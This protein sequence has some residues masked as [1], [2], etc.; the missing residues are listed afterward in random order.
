[1]ILSIYS[2]LVLLYSI[3]GGKHM[4]VTVDSSPTKEFFVE[5]LTRDIDLTDAILDLLDNCLDGVL[6]KSGNAN[7]KKDFDYSGYVANIQIRNDCFIIQDNCGGISKHIAVSSAFR[8]GRDSTQVIDDNLPT[9]GIYG[10]GMKRAIF[11]I[12]REAEVIS[13]C[14]NE[15]FAVK[16]PYEWTQT[17]SWELNLYDLDTVPSEI[18]EGGVI[19]RISHLTPA[20]MSVWHDDDKRANFVDDLCRSI[21]KSYSF[22]IEKGF[23]ITVNGQVLSSLPVKLLVADAQNKN[24]AISPYIYKDT[25]NGVDVDLIVGFYT[26]VKSDEEIDAINTSH[27][28]T[29]DA[30]WTIICNDRVVLY[31]DKTHLT[32]WGEGGIPKYHTQFI[33][34]KGV[35]SFRS[36]NP[37]L[38]PTTTT[39][40]GIDLSSEIYSQV[41]ERMRDGLGMFIS[42]T[43]QWK[44]RLPEE[45]KYSNQ[46]DSVS[47]QSL[48]NNVEIHERY[49][50]NDNLKN[51][52]NC[53]G[54]FYIPTLPKPEIRNTSQVI[55]FFKPT[56]EIEF[57][58]ESLLDEELD[59]VKP[60][61]IGELCFDR[62]YKEMGGK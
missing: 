51:K 44:G 20:I 49:S 10:I 50:L 11:K 19:V 55:R 31:N 62:V 47:M 16:I 41:K 35:V 27:R 57:L 9:V 48:L 56:T 40:R 45:R 14:N 23:C 6:R 15:Q 61:T 34:I 1:M 25:I 5:M 22:I 12:G 21:Q 18:S 7:I 4:T 13:R 38:L 37:R 32:G 54:T 39:K 26:P 60:S 28:S 36:S 2:K 29:A 42:Y 58:A 8:M 17:D 43:N 46:A 53:S 33:G 30:G 59:N 52:R 3:E 24:G